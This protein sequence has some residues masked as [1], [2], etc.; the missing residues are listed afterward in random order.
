MGDLTAAD[1][2]RLAAL[3]HAATPG[4]WE[5]FGAI[6]AETALVADTRTA[7]DAAFIAASRE[8]VPALVATVRELA[9]EIVAVE[10]GLRYRATQCPYCGGGYAASSSTFAHADDCIVR[11]A[12]ALVGE[13]DAGD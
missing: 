1:L 5:R 4:P 7:A 10:E 11:R 2:A 9:R 8:A 6:W 12:L 3:A 13:P